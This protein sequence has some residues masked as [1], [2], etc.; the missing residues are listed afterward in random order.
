MTNNNKGDIIKIE[1]ELPEENYNFL[2]LIAKIK[3]KEVNDLALELLKDLT[4]I[5]QENIILPF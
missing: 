5:Y 2:S 4:S 3:N 1:L